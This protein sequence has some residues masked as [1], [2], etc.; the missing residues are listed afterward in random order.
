MIG[1]GAEIPGHADRGRLRAAHA[2]RDGV[3]NTLKAAY[4]LGFVSK[5]ELDARVSQT[6]AARTYAELAVV[7]SDLPAGLAGAQSPAERASAERRAPASTI[8]RQVDRAMVACALLAAV[9]LA[10]A[11]ISDDAWLGLGAFGSALASLALLTLQMRVA[12]RAGQPGGQQPGPGQLEAGVRAKAGSELE[13]PGSIR[14]GQR[15]WRG[16]RGQRARG[17]SAWSAPPAV[18]RVPAT[19]TSYRAQA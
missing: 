11:I 15:I 8:R 2:D 14:R 1:P 13:S 17:K 6:L 16:Q 5:D 10:A 18:L 4:V 9:A 19:L 7:V 3:I 12:R